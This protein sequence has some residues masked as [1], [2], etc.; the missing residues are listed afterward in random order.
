ML[1]EASSSSKAVPRGSNFFSFAFDFRGDLL[2]EVRA[3]E[4]LSFDTVSATEAFAD[5]WAPF[6]PFRT[7]SDCNE[8]CCM[9]AERDLRR[10]GRRCRGETDWLE[11]C[12]TD[13]RFVP[14]DSF[15]ADSEGPTVRRSVFILSRGSVSATIFL[16][17]GL[18]ANTIGCSSLELSVS[19]RLVAN[20][21]RR[22]MRRGV[23]IL[24]K[25]SSFSEM[26]GAS[27]LGVVFIH[28]LLDSEGL[29]SRD[30][31]NGERT[32][33]ADGREERRSLIRMAGDATTEASAV[34]VQ[35]GRA[36]RGESRQDGAKTRADDELPSLRTLCGDI[37]SDCIR[38]DEL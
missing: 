16:A 8:T 11:D 20:V 7:A 24:C 21:R 17:V 15:F 18:A 29:R 5:R 12:V 34:F 22:R 3:A 14:E 31:L 33:A 37:T 36:L 38:R 32:L 28:V 23:G 2:R 13:R 35:R 26:T 30:R 6:D 19:T 4:R 1:I 27:T 10:L 25:S 9:E